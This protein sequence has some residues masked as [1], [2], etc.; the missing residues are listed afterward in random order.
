MGGNWVF[1]FVIRGYCS[2]VGLFLNDTHLYLHSI[3]PRLPPRACGLVLKST[4][5][6]EDRTLG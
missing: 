5:I 1:E 4:A 3:P 2:A 6:A